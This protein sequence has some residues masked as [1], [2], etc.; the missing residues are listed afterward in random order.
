MY[1][2]LPSNTVDKIGKN[3]TNSF[4]VDLPYQVS[5][6][7]GNWEMGLAEIQ[8]PKSWRNIA[9]P[10]K[11][12]VRVDSERTPGVSLLLFGTVQAGH[13]SDLPALLGALRQG[14]REAMLERPLMEALVEMR[15][16]HLKVMKT[17]PEQLIPK[18]FTSLDE[19]WR[20]GDTFSDFVRSKVLTVSTSTTSSRVVISEELREAMEKD[21]QLAAAVASERERFAK[22]APA[23]LSLPE[24]SQEK[25]LTYKKMKDTRQLNLQLSGKTINEINLPAE[26]QYILGLST[27]KLTK[28]NTLAKYSQDFTGGLT[29][30]YVN[31]DI[32]E[33][34]IV[35][36]VHSELLRTVAVDSRKHFGETV[37]EIYTSPH[38]LKVRRRQFDNV[39]I[40]IRSGTGELV[41]FEYGKVIIKIHFRK[42]KGL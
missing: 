29:T 32:V 3:R 11:I 6:A 31:C 28:G 9:Q 27:T 37:S 20:D 15:S 41:P 16:F 4:R 5:L 39:K 24:T 35:G 33:P 17:T 21:I 30:L 18:Y 22:N 25:E 13:Y 10:V 7:G 34:Q 38:Y 40:E 8:F 42:A 26:I 23:V 14:I 12:G 36:N 1:I 2:T 19:L